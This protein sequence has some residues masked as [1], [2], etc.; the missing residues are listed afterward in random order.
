LGREFEIN[1]EKLLES[2]KLVEI[3][4]LNNKR[5]LI[6]E[7]ELDALKMLEE[8]NP[9]PIDKLIR[10]P[11]ERKNLWDYHDN[12]IVISGNHVTELYL[13]EYFNCIS[14]IHQFHFLE[15]LSFVHDNET[16]VDLSN[17]PLLRNLEISSL[18]EIPKSIGKL[19]KLEKLRIYNH[20][21][22]NL[23]DFLAN[24]DNLVYLSISNMNEIEKSK[25]VERWIENIKLRKNK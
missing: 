17:F 16:L 7:N 4:T 19:R 8:K 25:K 14:F 20:D 6:H 22:Q 2:R 24:L 10:V 23:P 15:S 11:F 5:I 9:S 12:Y 18:D 3:S 1:K 21:L 13:S